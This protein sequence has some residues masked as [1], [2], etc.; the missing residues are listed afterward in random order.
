MGGWV[1]WLY[2]ADR[3]DR[4]L[5]LTDVIKAIKDAEH[6]NAFLGG[7]A[8]EF[9]HCVV[10]VGSVSDSVCATDEHLLKERRK[11]KKKTRFKKAG[12]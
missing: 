1:G 3:F 10:G 7:E 8:D 11:R 2:L 12:E 5:H 6:V 4:D 9:F